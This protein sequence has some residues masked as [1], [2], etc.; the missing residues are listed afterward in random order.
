MVW[1]NLLVGG[2]NMQNNFSIHIVAAPE[3]GWILRRLA[4]SYSKYL[5]NCTLSLNPNPQADINFYINYYLFQ[6]KT[7]SCDIGFFTHK[8]KDD[9]LS[10]RFNEIVSEVDWCVSMCQKTS[11]FLPQEKTT[12]ITMAPDYKFL[13]QKREI[14]LGV[15]GR[16]YESGRKRT[17]WINEIK[18][19]PG[20]KIKFTDQKIPWI[21]MPHFYKKIDYLLVLSD[22]EGGPIPVLEAL[23]MGVPIISSDVGFVKEYT[24]IIYKNKEDLKD[25]LRRLVI[26]KNI[27]EISSSQLIEAFQLALNKKNHE[28]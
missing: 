6:G 18:K 9:F 14:I 24:T 7:S 22:N 17:H 13:K 12:T 5:N 3:K 19:I 20:I 4:E 21:L 23:S 16:E 11:K 1:K 26:P 28:K 2:K 25:K 8:E 27:W 10:Q 15:V